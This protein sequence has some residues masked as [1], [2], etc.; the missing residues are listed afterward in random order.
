MF[1]LQLH[2]IRSR[3]NHMNMTIEELAKA[4]GINA[5]NISRI[6]TGKKGDINA[7]TLGKLASA[8]KVTPDYFFNKD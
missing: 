7:T 3:R 5:G 4:S 1:E 2:K 8:L 6:E